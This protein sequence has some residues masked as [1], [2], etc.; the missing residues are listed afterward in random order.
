MRTISRQL[1][2]F[3]SLLLFVAVVL[4]VDAQT[5]HVYT[6]TGRVVD[7][8]GRPVV[9]A[10]VS[11]RSR[12]YSEGDIVHGDA[13][14]SLGKF[15]IQKKSKRAIWDWKLY[16]SAG[17]SEK[18]ADELLDVHSGT[19]FC[20]DYYE[21]L[22]GTRVTAIANRV[23]R[24]GDVRL[25]IRQA[26]FLIC[27][28]DP[29]GNPLISETGEFSPW[30]RVRDP[31]GDIIGEG[32]NAQIHYRL[33]ES[34]VMIGLPVGKWTVEISDD[35]GSGLTGSFNVD[36]S[37]SKQVRKIEVAL[38]T[39]ARRHSFEG[40]RSY[41]IA[42]RKDARQQIQQRGF[43]FSSTAFERRVIL[44]NHEM[45]ELYL[46][47]GM[48]PN[49]LTKDDDTLMMALSRPRVLKLLLEA[50]ADVNRRV[51][52]GISPLLQ[53]VG[54]LVIP[55]E[56][57]QMLLDAGADINAKADDGRGPFELSED[58]D[59]VRQL[60]QEYKTRRSK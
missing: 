38:Q 12:F 33:S 27:I 31:L 44:G 17:V 57:V 41:A 29:A 48:A 36:V 52:R 21:M 11:L 14:D 55:K 22:C 1:F 20:S 43:K 40:V 18:D 5:N 26:P 7:E 13:T 30:W 59:E 47:A 51:E 28:H 24:V 25:R 60:L 23:T 39:D 37:A 46:R 56:T 45:V 4:S 58:R 8:S 42:D 34:A 53:A 49:V 6:V 54:W 16:V 50:G 9:G 15:T 2:Q 3:T 35:N 10:G 19:A 32:G